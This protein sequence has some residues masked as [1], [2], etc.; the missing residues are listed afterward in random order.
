MSAV[1]FLRAIRLD[2]SDALVFP[3][4]AEP[5][6]WVVSGAF[7]FQGAPIERMLPKQR[8]A[9]RSGFLGVDDL[10][11]TTLAVVA[12]AS[13]DD[14]ASAETRLASNLVARFGAPANEARRAAREEVAFARELADRPEGR[15]IAVSRALEGGEIVER[16]RT[17]EPRLPT[18]GPQGVG[19]VF[20]IVQEVGRESETGLARGSSRINP[21]EAQTHAS[22]PGPRALAGLDAIGDAAPDVLMEALNLKTFCDRGAG[23]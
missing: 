1:K 12:L 11:W 9:M 22:P 17:L 13:P 4:A 23:S 15:W 10:G 18:A 5:G 20:Q 19:R 16:F 3:S 8:V 6:Q 14:V 21:L 7:L 2:P